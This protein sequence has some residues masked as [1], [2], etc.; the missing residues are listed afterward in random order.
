MNT[1][2]FLDKDRHFVFTVTQD[3]LLICKEPS[4]CDLHTLSSKYQFGEYLHSATGPAVIYTKNLKDIFLNALENSPNVQKIDEQ[5]AAYW[6]DG[7]IISHEQW[8]E[9]RGE[10]LK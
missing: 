6:L 4:E 3:F 10:Y 1:I 7:E 8:L 9:R 5:I 2:T